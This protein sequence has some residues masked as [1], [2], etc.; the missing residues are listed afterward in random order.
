M[1]KF[2][3]QSSIGES[4]E[5]VSMPGFDSVVDGGSLDGVGLQHLLDRYAVNLLG[6]RVLDAF[7]SRF[8][9]LIK[10]IDAR[11]KLSIQVHPNDALAQKRHGSFGKSEMW[12][13]L[14]ADPEAYVLAGFEEPMDVTEYLR[15]VEDENLAQSLKVIPVRKG[16]IIYVPSG[17]VHAIGPGVLLAEVQQ[18]SDITYRICDW[19][20][21]DALGRSRE[22]HTEMS[23]DAID[24]SAQAF[25]ENIR[26]ETLTKPRFRE[27][28]NEP[29]FRISVLD[30]CSDPLKC[31]TSGEFV[32]YICVDGEVYL[33]IGEDVFLMKTGDTVLVPAECSDHTLRSGLNQG[34]RVLDVRFG[35]K[36]S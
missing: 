20:R 31:N 17:L 28:L 33:S 29:Y 32:V 2:P 4:W 34:G 35:I 13:I 3:G 8:P 5:L 19:G 7:G 21:V 1:D 25:H 18:P 22:L 14:D 36:K 9:L 26:L 10:W 27:V 11:E 16:D 15:R 24:F 12:Y 6:Q 30:L 23:I